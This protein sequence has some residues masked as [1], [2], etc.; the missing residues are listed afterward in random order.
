[1]TGPHP[2]QS[3][4]RCDVVMSN[5]K[6]ACRL[7][8]GHDGRHEARAHGGLYRWVTPTGAQ[9]EQRSGG[10]EVEDMEQRLRDRVRREG[11]YETALR[12]IAATPHTGSP[13]TAWEIARA[14]L[15]EALGD[16]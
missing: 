9:H 11:I 7:P 8:A 10:G 3:G 15:R 12:K 14:A 4:P 5:T 13:Y 16:G 1:M 2:T 6:I